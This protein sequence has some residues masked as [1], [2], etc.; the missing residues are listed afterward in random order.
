[1]TENLLKKKD[2]LN[3]YTDGASRGNPGKGAGAFIFLK[4]DENVIFEKGVEFLGNKI[5]NNVA[6]YQAI[7][8]ALTQA[9]KYASGNIKL[10]SDSELVVKQL[11]KI[12]KINKVHLKKK[13]NKIFE[14]MKN[15]E[16]VKFFHVRRNNEFIQICDKLCNDELDNYY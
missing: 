10:Y 8:N 15:F 5:T 11:S 2:V 13:A 16:S 1:M 3:I 14:L 6:E 4:N 9:V 12:Y 7:I